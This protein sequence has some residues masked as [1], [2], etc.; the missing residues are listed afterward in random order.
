MTASEIVDECYRVGPGPGPISTSLL[1]EGEPCPQ[2]KRRSSLP[3]L[4]PS[5]LLPPTPCVQVKNKQEAFSPQLLEWCLQRPI[6]VIRGLAQ[7]CDLAKCR[8]CLG[9]SVYPTSP[10]AV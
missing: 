9:I 1:D 8:E 3:Q 10:S 4:S 2:P 6:T 7:S 5:Q